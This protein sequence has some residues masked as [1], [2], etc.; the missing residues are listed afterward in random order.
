MKS[1]VAA[2]IMYTAQAVTPQEVHEFFAER[3]MICET[4]KQTVDLWGAKDWEGVG[5]LFK[6]LP[7]IQD[8]L[9]PWYT[10]DNDVI[11]YTD[12]LGSCQRMKACAVSSV[13]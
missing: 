1:F 4:C 7:A 2:L 3:N 10:Y 11:D 5:E 12:S 6:K 8:K 9:F 13:S